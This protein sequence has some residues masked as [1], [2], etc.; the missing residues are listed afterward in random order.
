MI[1]KARYY[2]TI[3]SETVL[4]ELCPALCRLTPGKRGI[5]RSRYNDNGVLKTDNFGETVTVAIDP[6]EKKPLYHFLPGS[7]IVSIG[8]N[9]CNLACRHCQNWQIS[10]EKTPTT[11]IPPE[12]LSDIGAREGSIG[13]AFTY[14]EPVIWYEYIVETAP[15]LRKN[16]LAVVMVSNGYINPEPMEELLPVVD[17]F[18]IDIKGMRPEFYTKICKGKL[19]P[20]QDAI[21]QIAA[22]PSHLEL[23]NLI[24]TDLNDSDEDFHALG[25]FIASVDAA[26]PL[27]LSAY[28]PTYKL[29]N[30]PTESKTLEKAHKILSSYLSYVFVGNREIAGCSHS[31]CR[32]CGHTLIERRGYNIKITGLESDSRCG[33]CHTPSGIIVSL[34]RQEN[35]AGNGA[36]RR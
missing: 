14:T 15:L 30:P 10:Q 21:R 3:D 25:E 27:H 31:Y 23:T 34:I 33:K 2:K 1:H 13:V 19:E 5:C 12:Q 6:I 22:S 26:I 8:A 16:G 35:S 7:D 18:N 36:S 24:I 32:S 9:G 17:A 20:V 28:Y 11:Y 4:C 29:T